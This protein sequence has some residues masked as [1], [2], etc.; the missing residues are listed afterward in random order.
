DAFDGFGHSVSALTFTITKASG[1]W[2]TASDVLTA[3]SNGAYAAAHIFVAGAS[4]TDS[5]GK[6][7][8]CATGYAANGGAHVPD[9]GMTVSLL[10]LALGGL[11][12]VAR[13]R[14]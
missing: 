6:P 1:T 3:N 14:N 11:G 2:A 13:R 9:G 4:C 8:A 12:M 5:S 7:D 10:G